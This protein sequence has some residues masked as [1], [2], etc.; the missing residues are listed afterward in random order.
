MIYE[1]NQSGLIQLNQTRLDAIGSNRSLVGSN[2]S[3]QELYG[4]FG[5]NEMSQETPSNKKGKISIF[6]QLIYVLIKMIIYLYNIC[7]YMLTILSGDD[8][9]DLLIKFF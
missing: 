4:Y 1:I 7:E 5:K 9:A 6:I 2:N 8:T 3:I